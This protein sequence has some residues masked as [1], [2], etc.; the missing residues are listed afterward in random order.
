MLSNSEMLMSLNS[1][2]KSLCQQATTQLFHKETKKSETVRK[3]QKRV[4]VWCLR[5]VVLSSSNHT[6]PY[7]L[8]WWSLTAQE[9]GRF[10]DSK[11]LK[12]N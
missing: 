9:K 2:Q 7:F 12:M 5:S 6:Y 11:E 4:W 8:S 1:K 3:W 10:E